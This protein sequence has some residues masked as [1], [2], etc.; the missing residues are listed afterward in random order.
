MR[1]DLKTAE[2][3]IDA[4]GGLPALAKLTGRKDSGVPWN[5]KAAGRFP[6]NT[7]LLMQGALRARGYRAP[8]ELWGM[9]EDV[10]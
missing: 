2:D 3:V 8:A 5:W 4:L 7:F 1:R 6:P 10:G 9:L